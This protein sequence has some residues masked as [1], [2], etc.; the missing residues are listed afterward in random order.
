MLGKR[1]AEKIVKITDVTRKGEQKNGNRKNYYKK[2]K[3]IQY[4]K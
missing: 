1:G 3:K 4:C 2:W